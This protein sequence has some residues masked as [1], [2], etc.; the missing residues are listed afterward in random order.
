MLKTFISV[1]ILFLLLPFRMQAGDPLAIDPCHFSTEGTDFWFGFMQNRNTGTEHYTEVTVTSRVGA[2]VK[3]TYGPTEIPIGS[4]IIPANQSVIVPISYSLLEAS[5]SETTENKGIHLTSDNPVNVYALN[6][7]TQSSDVAVIYPTESLGTEYFAMCYSPRF[8]SAGNESNSEFLIVASED[9]TIVKI[10]PTR[11][12]DKGKP[13]KVQ[14]SVTLNKGQMYQV[15]A[16]NTDMTGQEDLTGS[17]VT[18][19]KPVAFFSGSKA[20][21]IP[22]PV[23]GSTSYDHLFE[24][25]PPT[26]TWGREF[27]V[28]PLKLRD[29]D[30]Y[31][32][33]AAED[34]TIIKI[35]ATG[36]TRT[37]QKG[38]FY[39]FELFNSQACRI[40][41]GKKV[42][43]TQYCRSQRA[44]ASSGVGDPF[45]IVLSPVVQE[46]R[47]VTFEAYESSRVKNIFYVN[48][49]A[50]T[51]NVPGMV[52]DGSNV[53]AL[54]T[55]FPDGKYSYAQIPITKGTHRLNNTL[56]EG[57][58]LAFVYGFGDPGSTESYGYGVGFNL[59]LQ[60]E[61]GGSFVTT[62]TLVLCQ[63]LDVKLE[64]GEYF[65]SYKW[66]TG[67]TTSYIHAATQGWFWVKATTGRGCML[68]D[69]LYIK[70][71]DPKINLGKDTSSCGPGK[72]VLD[73]GAGFESYLW[74]DGSTDRKF[75]VDKTGDYSVTGTNIF[76]C[77]TTDK[78]HVDVFEIPEV[79]ITGEKHH[80]GVF[81][82]E[83]KVDINLDPAL[84]NY[85]GAGKWT[86][87]QAELEFINPKP[88]GVTLKAKK[89]GLYQINYILTTKDGCTDTDTYEVGFYEIPES[90]FVVESGASTDKCSTYE[91]IV[92]YTGKNGPS[93]KYHWDFGGLMVLDT[94]ASNQFKVSIGANQ[95][96]RTLKLVV[97]EN[98]CFSPETSISIG[99]DPKFKFW[100]DKIHGCDSA[101]IQFHA[102]IEIMDKVEYFW[103]FGDGATSSLQNPLHRYKSTGKYDVSLKVTNLIDGCMNGSV[104]KEMIQIFPT[105]KPKI[106]A[107][108]EFCYGDTASFEYLSPKEN[109]HAKWLTKGNKILSEENI[110][111][112]YQLTS[113]I[114]E[115]GFLVEEDGCTC[116]TLKVLV[117]R[118]PN[119]DF[120]VSETEIC[121]PFPVTMKALPADP[122]L[123]FKWSVDTL[124]QIAGDSLKHLF[125]E[126]GFYTVTLEAFSN[127]TG[128]S[129]VLTKKDLIHVYPLPVPDFVQNY[130]IA[131]IE[132][133]EITFS[134]QSEGAVS[135]LWDFGDGTTSEEQHPKHQ[136]TAIGEYQI[137]LQAFTDF[138]CTDTITSGVKIIPF[139][140][141]VPNAFRPD[142]HIAE[143]QI[144]LPIREGI[145][146]ERYK[147][148]VFNRVGSRVF[149]SSNP[150]IG[151]NGIMPNNSKAEPG[152]YVWVVQFNDV[153]GY[154]HLQK[155][156]VMLVR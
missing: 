105:P 52:L 147:F 15:Q 43:L 25:I 138:G 71:S 98:G 32:I 59:D 97:E 37:L 24:Q 54:F 13:A 76:G 99:V 2:N 45:M 17:Y 107:N 154:E 30:T 42:L 117:K 122:N 89:P 101:V 94:L 133:P 137:V 143:N 121:Q 108:P 145:D 73:A 4:Y 106:S 64:A 139:T 26:T 140:F 70:I 5:G 156:T 79:K 11:T 21:T 146:K 56:G 151:W 18:S 96:N 136:Y 8:T 48:V 49:I 47:D 132:H 46:I 93:A 130:T 69:S 1:I 6:Y 63:G 91:R 129:D 58:F 80:C 135:Y 36:V 124:V 102:E 44:D 95:T 34:N 84:W 115:V 10:T 40:L 85:S 123:E 20:V 27:Y 67:D 61:L 86:S 81:T 153:Q 16:G 57:G 12:T 22:I 90:S 109:S 125:P 128:C 114:S 111:A 7:R 28:V 29:K 134:N 100:A 66:N 152:V 103:T 116:D 74:Q 77:S 68:T 104:E 19:N 88:D 82:S 72:I 33:L 92:K 83:L 31:R 113:E 142:S 126:A 65:E 53:G 155:G 55:T 41:S 75:R 119:F 9:N 144:F 60:L 78:I 127:L 150:E 141:Y 120:E 23:T 50:Q 35:E 110:K 87:P 3:V 112:E 148:E 51:E 131:T 149:S 38:E 14:F 62:D 39:E 118:R